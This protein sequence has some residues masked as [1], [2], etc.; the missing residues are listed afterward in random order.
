MKQEFLELLNE[1]ST[2]NLYLLKI[3]VSLLSAGLSVE[4]VLDQLQVDR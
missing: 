2:E 3:A 4:E 1:L